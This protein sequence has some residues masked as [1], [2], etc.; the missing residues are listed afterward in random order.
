MEEKSSVTLLE[1]E[2]QTTQTQPM[3][4]RETI[5][6]NQSL[7]VNLTKIKAQA[8]KPKSVK[9]NRIV[10]KNQINFFGSFQ[11]VSEEAK[12]VQKQPTIENK[13]SSSVIE[14]PNYDFI[15]PLSEAE[16]KKIFK[17]ERQKRKKATSPLLKKIKI[18]VFAL[19]F[20]VLGSW[21]VYNAVELSNIVTE[22]SLK[23]DQY[24]LK[25]GTLDSASN[26]NDLFPTYPEGQ[27]GAS[28]F[29]KQSNWFDRFCNFIAGIFGG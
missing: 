15:E 23:L 12:V 22:Y 26:A 10:G 25:L 28:G 21:T 13:A 24:L 9:D 4:I 20:A 2:V 14:T 29:E 6:S 19:L 1:K 7:K 8:A 11:E 5:T 3:Q 16:Q 27:T 18:V 17:I